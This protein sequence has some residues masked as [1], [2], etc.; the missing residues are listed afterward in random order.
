MIKV[1]W[2]KKGRIVKRQRKEESIGK[3]EVGRKRLRM[4][5]FKK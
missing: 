2:E 3:N 4:G 1:L 5:V